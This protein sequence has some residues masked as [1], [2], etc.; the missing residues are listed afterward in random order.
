M[1][2]REEACVSHPLLHSVE[3]GGG[4]RR[5]PPFRRFTSLLRPDCL[6]FDASEISAMRRKRT[7]SRKWL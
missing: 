2:G 7:A 5:N 6:E 3:L 1:S 4:P